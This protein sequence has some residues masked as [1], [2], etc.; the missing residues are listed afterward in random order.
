MSKPFR[1]PW[2]LVALDGLGALILVL[3]I[4]GATGV[5]IGLPVLI[6]LWPFLVALGALLMVPMAVW[7][8]RSMH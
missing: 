8:L 4:L 6:Q 5:D 3:G 1:L 2:F 7:V